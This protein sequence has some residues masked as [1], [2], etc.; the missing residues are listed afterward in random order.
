MSATTLTAVLD[1]I[2]AAQPDAVAIASLNRPPMGYPAFAAAT[3]RVAEGLARQGIGPGDSVAL[4][5]PNRP[6][7]PVLLLA[8]AR[9]GAVAVPLDPRFGPEELVA[10]L[11]RARPSAVATVWSAAHATL[12]ERLA[13]ALTDSRAPLRF[14]IGLDAG[15]VAALAGLPVLPWKALDA[16]PE[17]AADDATPESVCL[18]MPAGEGRL[19]RH[20]QQGVAAHAVAVAARLALVPGASALLPALPFATPAGHAVMM[21][22]L[23]AGSRLLCQEE[24]GA[25]ATDALVRAHGATHLFAL[26]G[27]V[28]ALSVLA[29]RRPYASLGFAGSLGEAVAPGLPLHEFWGN[30]ETQGLFALRGEAGFLP[31]PAA[32]LRLGPTLEI[33]AATL[34]VGYC[35]EAADISPDGFLRTGEPATLADGAFLPSGPR[36]D[37]RISLDGMDV[38]PAEVARFLA[39]QPGV[40]EAVVVP[41]APQGPLVAFLRPVAREEGGAADGAMPDEATL[42]AACRAA[43]AAPKCPARIVVTEDLPVPEAAAAAAASL[44]FVAA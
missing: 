36:P 3:R 30:A 10:L 44:A 6:E 11:S 31:V 2:A 27:E 29:A 23:T 13:R 43:L 32:T 34:L 28:A 25:A 35:G 9:L 1:G 22:S 39:R 41:A 40:A 4:L 15:G 16:M 38:A 33:Q 42:L 12:P 14:V 37:G 21:A 24:P 19:A 17:R 8:L 26:A 18:A 5:L 7:V 20:T